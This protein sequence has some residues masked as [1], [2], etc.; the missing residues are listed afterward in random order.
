M[1]VERVE[2]GNKEIIDEERQT[3][4]DG[5]VGNRHKETERQNRDLDE[6]TDGACD[7]Y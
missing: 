7:K 3:D 5:E 1:E 4:I 6:E 2:E